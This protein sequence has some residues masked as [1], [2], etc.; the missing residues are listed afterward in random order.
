MPAKPLP[1]RAMI[2]VDTKTHERVR[3]EAAKRSLPVHAV[4]TLLLNHALDSIK[5]GEL[6]ISGPTIET[7][8]A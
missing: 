1:A 2:Q 6:K 5:S 7:P 4:A 8:T 3:K